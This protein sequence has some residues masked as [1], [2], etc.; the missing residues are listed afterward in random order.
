MKL[1]EL[2][3]VRYSDSMD[4]EAKVDA[5][6]T[7]LIPLLEE[8]ID[9][10]DRATDEGWILS[11]HYRKVIRVKP[12]P[13]MRPPCETADVDFLLDDLG[14]PIGVKHRRANFID[15]LA[16]CDSCH[17][18]K[19]CLERAEWEHTPFGIWGGLM[20]AERMRRGDTR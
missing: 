11:G 7:S 9:I 3:R 2:S 16:L 19:Q 14:H 1:D 18:T 12:E 17:M 5:A 13:P 4:L 20:P 6:A 8:I 10:L 15:R